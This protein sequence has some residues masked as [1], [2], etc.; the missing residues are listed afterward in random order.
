[1]G[2]GSGLAGGVEA[3]AAPAFARLDRARA[4]APAESLARASRLVSARTG[5]IAEVVFNEV[6]PEEPD[7]FWA[8][9]RPADLHPLAGRPALN[10]GNATAFE[11][12]RA[13]MKAVGESVERYCAALYDD[14]ELVFASYEDCGLPAADPR[15]FALFSDEQYAAPGFPFAAFT[16]R[17][18][19]NWVAGHSL[20]DNAPR[21]VPATFVYIPYDRP[22]AEP[23][24]KDLISTGLACGPTRAHATLKA[25]CEAV[26][27]DAYSIV[28]HNRLR[29]PHLDLDRARDPRIRQVVSALR[30]SPQTIHA[31]LLTLDIP[32]TSVLVVMTRADA[33]PYTVVA[34]GCDLSPRNALLLALEE[35]CLASIG[36]GRAAAAGSYA[37][38]EDYASVTS[39][40]MHGMAHALDP[41][42]RSSVEFLTDP[43][44]LVDVDDLPDPSTG[45][46]VDDL[47]RAVDALRGRATDA[48]AVDV[49]TP[50][51]DAAGF[52]V[53]RVVVPNLQPMDIDH[54]SRHLGGH[55]LY[56]VPYALGLSERPTQAADLNPAPHPFP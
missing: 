42:L 22:A 11:A 18:P 7:V 19:V 29:R 14:E 54:G 32:L 13:V 3:S 43:D 2:R 49:T 37:P 48:I 20:S 56:E 27:R 26:E 33:P 24:L 12:G 39:M 52:K 25:V 4:P 34:S 15:S 28:W 5:V 35:A 10:F 44:G 55:R 23:P 38:D 17:T 21:W 6:G 45:D 36:M 1:M 40:H 50:D 9:S 8:Q 53:V 30:R 47:G 16:T 41:R 46:P 51:I 31:V